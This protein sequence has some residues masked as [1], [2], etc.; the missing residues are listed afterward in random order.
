MFYTSGHIKKC[1]KEQYS[2][3]KL[4]ELLHFVPEEKHS[5]FRTAYYKILDEQTRRL[6]KTKQ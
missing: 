4:R 1:A 6:L 3:D 2:M 5:S